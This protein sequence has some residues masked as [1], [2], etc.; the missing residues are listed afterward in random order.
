MSDRGA[1]GQPRGLRRFPRR[2]FPRGFRRCPRRLLPRRRLPLGPPPLGRRRRE[3]RP[4]ESRRSGSG[5]A[6]RRALVLGLL[7]GLPAARL[8]PCPSYRYRT[9]L[10]PHIL[11][12]HRGDIER[13]GFLRRVR[14]LGAGIDAQIAQDAAPQRTAR[15]HPLDRL[16]DDPLGVLAGEDRALAAPLDAAGVAG[17]PV[18]DAGCRLVAGQPHLLGVDDDDVVATIHMR[19]VGRLV[20]AAQPHRDQ[21]GEPAEHQPVGVDQQPLLVDVGGFGGKGFHLRDLWGPIAPPI[22]ERHSGA[23]RL[24]NRCNPVKQKAL[25]NKAIYPEVLW[26]LF[27][28][29]YLRSSFRGA[30]QTVRPE[31]IF[32]RP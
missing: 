11:T 3:S 5:G 7:A 2:Q 9:S 10:C 1:A 30:A 18:E 17:V 28:N 14:M 13:L 22:G 25:R 26:Y 21:R 20:L 8:R 15:Y 4:F 29:G 27:T 12:V 24:G 19:R 6:A 23:L 32:Q 16:L 31:S